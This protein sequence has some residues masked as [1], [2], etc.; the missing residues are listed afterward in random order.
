MHK[1]T[2]VTPKDIPDLLGMIRQ[3]CAFHGDTCLMGLADTQEKFINGPLKGFIARHNGDA[4]GYAVLESHW[5]PMHRGDLYDIAHLFIVGPAR[6]KGVGKTLIAACQ[7]F[8][9][10]QGACRLVIGTSPDNPGAAAAYRAMGLEEITTAPGPR[11]KIALC[12]AGKVD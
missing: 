6:G 1:I 10:S 11:F 12:A 2:E 7:A 5:R 8:A 9:Q 3:L 4:I